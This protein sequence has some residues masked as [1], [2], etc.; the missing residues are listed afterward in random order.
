MMTPLKQMV[1]GIDAGG[2]QTR[3]ALLSLDGEIVGTGFSAGLSGMQMHTDS[4][5][6]AVQTRL[7]EVANQLSPFLRG[8]EI[9]ALVAGVTGVGTGNPELAVML[10]VSFRV[11]RESVSVVS[12]IE[13]AYHSA[14]EPGE[15]YLIY[16]GTGSI[17][18][19]IDAAGALHRAGGRGVQLDDAGG[20]YWIAREALRRIWR[21]EDES[22]NSWH[23]SPLARILFEKIGGQSS[24]YAARF[25]A[26][27]DR[28]EVGL[29]A[30]NVAQC[31]DTD[32]LATEI[33]TDAG[34][35]LARL[36]N[37]MLNRYGRRKIAVGGRAAQL[38]PL[39]EGAMRRDLPS[40]ATLKFQSLE[41]H[42]AASRLALKRVVL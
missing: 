8:G 30:I 25:L 36:A 42:F 3:W 37:A 9:R 19:Y 16:A 4:G 28:G 12:D 21:R 26:E 5:R 40:D 14:F 2:T 34:G 7:A 24:V 39:I 18:A 1:L 33:L 6:A 38:H 17:A 41:S 22:P 20:G 15:G 29:L 23:D 32:P 13:I 31:A 27:R 35:E 10:S 11:P